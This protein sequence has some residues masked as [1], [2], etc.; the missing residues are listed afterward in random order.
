LLWNRHA[1]RACVIEQTAGGAKSEAAEEFEEDPSTFHQQW[2]LGD[3]LIERSNAG[4][5][6]LE[7]S[8]SDLPYN[9]ER[10]L[11]YADF[12]A[13]GRRDPCLLQL[14]EPTPPPWAW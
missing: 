14:R 1:V 10:F 9:D 3:F 8:D 2:A 4:L 11:Y 6:L 7:K 13:E 12:R 5:D